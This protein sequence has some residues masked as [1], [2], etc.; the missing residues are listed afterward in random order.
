MRNT[1]WLLP[2]AIL[3][4]AMWVACSSSSDTG[5]A[6]A[7]GSKAGAGGT[8][9]GGQAG[10]AGKGGTSGTGGATGGAA[11]TGGATGGAAGTGGATGGAAGTGG[12]T[13]GAAGTGGT[14][15]CKDITASGF[16]ADSTY[17]FAEGVVAPN[18]DNADTDQLTIEL[19]EAN[20]FTQK[21]GTFDLSAGDDA[22]YE[23]CN[24]CV[25][26]RTDYPND[27]SQPPTKTFYVESGSA[28]FTEVTSPPT[29]QMKV[30]L[31]NV[32]L[33][34]V[35]VDSTTYHSTPVPGGECLTLASADVNTVPTSVDAGTPCAK[36]TD[37]GNVNA[38]VCDP[39]TATCQPFGCDNANPPKTCAATE[40]CVSQDENAVVGACYT[41]CTPMTGTECGATSECLSFGYA[42]TEGG[43]YAKGTGTAD[44]ACNPADSVVNSGCVAGYRCMSADPGDGGSVNVCTQMCDYFGATPTCAASGQSCWVGGYCATGGGDP[45][46]V[47]APCTTTENF[48][49]PQ[50]GAYR[51]LCAKAD[52]DAA[53]NTCIKICRMSV[54]G[55]CT[56]PL[57]CKDVL[58]VGGTPIT[59][60]GLCMP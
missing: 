54:P 57:S 36:A 52:A 34:E 41:K 39:K 20:G 25:L 23:T 53:V 59:D 43:C 1:A 13:G 40:L 46:A 6:G 45:A 33:I 21:A 18:L 12:A 28:E 2:V 56:S 15:T 29:G 31:T 58:T 38:M 51:G 8:Q 5:A 19:F 35:T 48:C 16:K 26:V 24:H 10:T 11:G 49:A 22:N 55:D 37:C 42:Q 3:G 9:T 7:G 47:G 27:G 4:A 17:A 60:I 14:V 44:A 30:K 32:K 50:G